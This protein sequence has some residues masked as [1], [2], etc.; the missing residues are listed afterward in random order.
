MKKIILF[1]SVIGFAA[2]LTARAADG[3]AL[4]DQHCAMCH[5]VDGK[6]QTNMGKR[7]GAKDYT[8]PAVQAALSDDA[9]TTAIKEGFKNKEGKTVMRP[10]QN[11]SDDEI[12]SLVAYLRTFKK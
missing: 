9:A 7:L 3:K 10:A 4:W 11:L 8:D 6:G 5:G 12:K 1:A 2:A